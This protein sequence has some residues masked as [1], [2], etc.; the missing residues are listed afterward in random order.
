MIHFAEP[1]WFLL[2][3]MLAL[4]GWRIRRLALFRPLR[5]ACMVLF[6][7]ALTD[8]QIRQTPQGLDLW[9]LVDRSDSAAD[10]ISQSG[11]EWEN[12]LQAS[13][14]PAHRLVFVDF[15]SAP[16]LRETGTAFEPSTKSSALGL[17]LN[18]ALSSRDPSRPTKLLALTDGQSTDEFAGIEDRLRAAGV[19][20]DIRLIP[21]APGEDYRIGQISA[22]TRIAPGQHFLLEAPV[23]GT[24][25]GSIPYEV[26]CDG[27]RVGGGETALHGG[28]GVVRLSAR[29][30]APGARRYEIRILPA[31]DSRPG[32]NASGHWVEVQSSGSVLLVTA[33]PDDP[34]ATALEAS[35]MTVEVITDPSRLHPGFLAGP[36]AVILNNIPANLLPAEF[37][38]AMEFFVS[39]QGGGLLMT[40]G[41]QSFGSGGYF[42]SPV[43][44]LLPV[45]MELRQEHRKLAVAM[46]IVMDR[47]G[48]M[49]AAVDGATTKMDLANEGAARAIQLL[50][51]ADAVTVFAVDSEP[52]EVVP[53]TVIGEDALKIGSQIRRIQSTG[54][55]IFVY[56]GLEAGWKELEK[57]GAGQRHIVLFSD[58][59][60]S[61]EPG[62]Y[63]RLL[64]TITSEGAT[65]SVIALGTP[66]DPDAA[67]LEDIAALGK[68]RIFFNADA[69][70]LPALFAQETVSVARSAFLDSPVPVVDAGG[71]SQISP[72]SSNWPATVDGYNLCYARPEASVATVSGD[73]YMAPLTTF[74]QRGAGRTAAV[75]F[76]V[77]G[78]NSETF[79]AWEGAAPFLQTLTRWL[80]PGPPPPGTSLKTRFSGSDL[81]IDFLF[82]ENLTGTY[83]VTPPRLLVA[84][85]ASGKPQN[86]TWQKISNGQFSATIPVPPG[87]WIRGVVDA[88]GTRI[89]FGPLAP[90]TDPEWSENAQTVQLLRATSKAS[91]GSEI[92]DLRDAWKS[93]PANTDFSLRTLLTI[94][95]LILAIAEIA[96]TR[97]T[98]R[99]A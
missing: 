35:G 15:A 57:S 91:G 8:P 55:G 41:R 72:R 46:A 16:V 43:D 26:L 11:K 98:G 19:P 39:E 94:G 13:Q 23:F 66:S 5:A 1:Q 68:G 86:V 36:R 96:A 84:A 25:D 59:A 60:D 38:A 95:L 85:G 31:Q 48:S 73:E 69:S 20:L 4:L 75:T 27:T 67:L 50:G 56:R 6:V 88:G 65:L 52:H 33:Y 89:G 9:V 81:T 79:R 17:A 90:G 30:E 99:P 44:S 97:W 83:S 22:P 49:G 2:L 78:R 3:P 64:E 47:S 40:G 29:L 28:R 18:F 70:Q 80:L 71:W 53:L 93:L 54:G 82:D 32:N 87:E 62:E 34:V 24:K 14:G 51:P 12:L 58:A 63:K 21:P 10:A 7:L 45:S 77:A 37:L 92:A 74:W 61:E 76:P 42:E